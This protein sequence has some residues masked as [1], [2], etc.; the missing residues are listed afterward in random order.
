MSSYHIN[1]VTKSSVRRERAIRKMLKGKFDTLVRGVREKD[2]S[3]SK[4]E[5]GNIGFVSFLMLF[6]NGEDN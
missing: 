5:N 3:I 2:C 6:K 4:Q 1:R